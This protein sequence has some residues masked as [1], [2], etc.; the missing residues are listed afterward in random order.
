MEEFRGRRGHGG[1][2]HGY[3]NYPYRYGYGSSYY[4]PY[5]YNRPSTVYV[6]SGGDDDDNSIDTNTLI[7]AG[8]VVFAVFMATRK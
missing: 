8:V 5:Y 2:R 7:L 4:W 3:Y 6:D 1:R